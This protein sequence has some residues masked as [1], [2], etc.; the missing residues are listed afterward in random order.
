VLID[1]L[2]DLYRRSSGERFD[3]FPDWFSTQGIAVLD[4]LRK[5]SPPYEMNCRTKR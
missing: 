3:E 5:F 1:V 4:R 2:L